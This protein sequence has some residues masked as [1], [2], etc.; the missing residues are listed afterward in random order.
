MAN[1]SKI[2]IWNMALGYIGT[3]TVASES[4]RCEEAIQCALYWDRAR[5][6]ALRDFPYNFAQA[7][8]ALAARIMP[9]VWEHQWRFAYGL[10]DNCLKLHSVGASNGKARPFR[11][12]HDQEGSS[13]LLTDVEA[14]HAEYTR[15]V[16]SPTL[17]DDLFV[18][19][20]ARKL[21]AM[22]AVPLLKNNS[23]KVSELE[24]L[25]RAELPD[26]YEAGASEQKDKPRPDSWLE[27]R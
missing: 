24:Q 17:W 22:I 18:G 26:A 20:M 15:D 10:P 19:M 21:A 8:V 1:T 2:Q 13:L 5:R 12:V 27:A 14:A 6:Q 4:E 23:G 3:R 16:E 9:E 7:R 11:I 25:Y